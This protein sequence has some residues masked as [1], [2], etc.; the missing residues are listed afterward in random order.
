MYEPGVAYTTV[1]TMLPLA[2][3]QRVVRVEEEGGLIA[4]SSL[5]RASMPGRILLHRI[6]DVLFEDRANCC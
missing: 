5:W 1:L 4:I 3:S 6:T 2:A